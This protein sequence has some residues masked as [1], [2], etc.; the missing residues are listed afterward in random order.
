MIYNFT[1]RAALAGVASIALIAAGAT[2]AIAENWKPQK[3]I[4]M[5]IMAGQGGGAD[6]LAR[7]FQSIIQK[8]NL[9]SMPVLPVNKGGGSGAEALRYMKENAGDAHKIMATLN[10]YYTTP[11]RTDIGVDIEEFTPI[12]RMALDTFVLWVNADSDIQ[13]MDDWVAA[14][15]ASGG[16]WK[17]GGTDTGQEDSLVTA[18]L[19][20]EFDI[21]VTY[22]P[23]KGGGDVAKNLVGGHIDSTVNNPSEQMGFWQA[24]KSRPIAAFT[25]ERLAVFPDV[26]TATELGHDIVYWMQRSFVAPKDMPAEAVAYYTDMFQKLSETEEWQQYTTDKALMADFLSGDELQTYFL[27]ERAKHATILTDMEGEGSS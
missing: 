2:S 7:L 22:V 11:L 15:K 23:F 12:A 26:P 25:P 3:P 9:A 18:M 4:E 13:T 10:S 6:R 8:E 21:K 24:G 5:V 17:M 16:E 1:R 19:E 27:E 20:K 14:V